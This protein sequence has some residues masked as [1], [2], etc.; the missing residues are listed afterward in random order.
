MTTAQ[1]LD[2]LASPADPDD[3]RE[4]TRVGINVAKSY[5][6]KTPVLRGIARQIGKDHFPRVLACF[7]RRPSLMI[8]L[9]SGTN[10]TRSLSKEA[11]SC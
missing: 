3:H 5:G 9:L 1:G 2:Q 8:K 10:E 7:A 4:M 11:V 6:I